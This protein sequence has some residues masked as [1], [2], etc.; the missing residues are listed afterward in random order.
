LRGAGGKGAA[1]CRVSPRRA[2][3]LAP[4]RGPEIAAFAVARSML[5][6]IEPMRVLV[7]DDEPS[8]RKVISLAFGREDVVCEVASGDELLEHLAEL[9][10]D[11]IITDVQLGRPDGIWV[12]AAARTA[13]VTTP[14]IVISGDR[15]RDLDAAVRRLGR[16]LFL[17]KPFRLDEL[18][19]AIAVASGE[20]AARRA[21]SLFPGQLERDRSSV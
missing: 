15:V 9:P 1:E 4:D 6:V 14:A 17:P 18:L 12:L 11:L 5:Q 7:A 10:F 16:A 2:V 19:G 3:A 20:S 13:G 8:L 21:W